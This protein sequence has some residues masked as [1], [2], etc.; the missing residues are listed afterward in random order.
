MCPYR[1]IGCASPA[2]VTDVQE[3]VFAE[4]M[5]SLHRAVHPDRG[6]DFRLIS[7]AFPGL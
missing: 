2:G 3:L 4:A 1:M 5:R 6:A 7:I